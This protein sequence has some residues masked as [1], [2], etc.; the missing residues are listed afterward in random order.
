MPVTRISYEDNEE[1]KK[2]KLEEIK[3]AKKHL[4]ATRRMIERFIGELNPDH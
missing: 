1:A 3:E 4:A 2:G